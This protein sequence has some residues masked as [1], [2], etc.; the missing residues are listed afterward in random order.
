MILTA[1][2]Q[3]LVTGDVIDAKVV[4]GQ[5]PGQIA[6]L[7]LVQFITGKGVFRGVDGQV[8]TGLH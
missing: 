5:Y 1:D 8:A 7:F 4:S 3:V 2:R 6:V